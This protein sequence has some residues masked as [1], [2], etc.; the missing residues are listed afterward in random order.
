MTATGQS[1]AERE[2]AELLVAALNLEHIDAAAVDPSAPLFGAD[3]NG[4]GLDSIDALEMALAIKQRYGVELR[5][6]DETVKKAFESLRS[7]TALVAER[8]AA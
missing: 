3:R 2:M 1:A 4:W 7:L 6:E 5:S 8:R